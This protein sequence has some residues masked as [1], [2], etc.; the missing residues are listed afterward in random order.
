MVVPAFKSCGLGCVAL[1]S[2]LTSRILAEIVEDT[3]KYASVA[4]TVAVY[5]MPAVYGVAGEF[6]FPRLDPGEAISPGTKSCK[7]L[8]AIL[9]SHKKR[10]TAL[11][12]RSSASA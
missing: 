7:R 2:L 12:R 1:G 3:L 4:F 8:A 5:T 6:V 10:N 11:K 9:L